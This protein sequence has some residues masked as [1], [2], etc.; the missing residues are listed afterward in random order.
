MTRVAAVSF[1]VGGT[2]L[3]MDPPPE[4]IFTDLC[5]EVGVDVTP[6]AVA[7]AYQR[8]EPWFGAHSELYVTSPEQ[9]WLRGN[10]VLLEALG[11]TEDLDRRA[12]IITAEFPERQG[13]WRAYPEVPETLEALRRRGLRLGVVSNWDPGLEH[14]LERL[15]LRAAFSVVLGSADVGVAKP[16]P[17]IFRLATSALGVVPEQ[18]LH[19]GDLYDY[20]IVGARAAGLIPVLLDR[21]EL[22]R[23]G[24]FVPDHVRASYDGLRITELGELLPIIEGNAEPVGAAP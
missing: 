13:D 16:D 23:G 4:V 15:E 22:A 7:G 10:R 20:D 19:V 2:L 14:L 6:E 18:T 3:H 11:V 17:R 9:F 1:D 8:A 24:I 5:R 21:R 12:E